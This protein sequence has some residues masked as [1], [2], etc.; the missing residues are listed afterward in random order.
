MEEG[1]QATS[2]GDRPLRQA[3]RLAFWTLSNREQQGGGSR[4]KIKVTKGE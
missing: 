3:L 1:F 2:A 4:G